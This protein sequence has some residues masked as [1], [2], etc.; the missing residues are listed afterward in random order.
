MRS[1][2]ATHAQ[3]D[4][5]PNRS[6]SSRR[7]ARANADGASGGMVDVGS[8]PG[9]KSPFGAFD[10]TGNAWEWT[11]ADMT[12][13]PG[14]KLPEDPKSGTKVLRGGNYQSKPHQATTTYRL[15]WM[16]SGEKEYATTGFRCV[17]DAPESSPQK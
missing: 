17:R 1:P 16:A 10:M 11:A 5:R 12:A 13:Y 4:C 2:S 3:K 8:Y 6:G 7:A 9:G 15:G 14:G